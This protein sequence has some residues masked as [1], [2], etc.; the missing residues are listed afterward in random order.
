MATF[1]N[2]LQVQAKA[3]ISGAPVV[4]YRGHFGVL[5]DTWGPRPSDGHHLTLDGLPCTVL[6][7]AVWLALSTPESEQPSNTRASSLR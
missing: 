7:A 2:I 1:N 4:I 5:V 3:F 6:E